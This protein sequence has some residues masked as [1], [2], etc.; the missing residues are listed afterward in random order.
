MDKAIGCL[1]PLMALFW[2]ICSQFLIAVMPDGLKE[3]L[4]IEQRHCVHDTTPAQANHSESAVW[5]NV[6]L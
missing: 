2:D 5:M 6:S 4:H 1:L 3:H